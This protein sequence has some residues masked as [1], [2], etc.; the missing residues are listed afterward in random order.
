MVDCAKKAEK[1]FQALLQTTRHSEQVKLAKQLEV[2]EEFGEN[3]HVKAACMR[4]VLML[5]L[6]QGR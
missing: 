6:A 5:V 1:E 3:T 4:S 2:P